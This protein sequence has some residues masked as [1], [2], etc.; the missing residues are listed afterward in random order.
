MIS[1]P[2]GL[3]L[4]VPFCDGK[5]FYCDFY[6]LRAEEER[7][8]AYTDSME[9]ALSAWGAKLGRAA[10]TL[11]FGGGTP[12]L[13]GAERVAALVR[14]AR[15]SFQLENAEITLE[16]NPASDL[17][18]FF[19]A[20]R[21][22]GVNRL[23]I[24][25]QSADEDELRLLGRRHTA[26]QAADAVRAAR[27]AGFDNISLDLMLATPGQTKD[28]LRRSIEF[29]AEAG[30][31]HVSAYLLAVEP[32]TAFAKRRES[33]A[34]PDDGEAGERY[35]FA[36][37]ELERYGFLQYEIS[38][39]A[40][41]GF[42]SR[43]NLKYWRCEEYLGLGPAAHSFLD[44]KRFYYGRSLRDFLQGEEPVPD[45]EGGGFEEYAM[46]ALRLAE[47]LDERRC[48]E[49]FGTGIPPSVWAAERVY[50]RAGLT[51]R[52]AGG[53]R[54]TRR[55]FLVSNTLLAELLASV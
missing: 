47:G 18:G 20:I 48:R 25:L 40:R 3:Y 15:D 34:L 50:E 45:G 46:L 7:M 33:L 37:E 52:T 41:P 10:D 16:A 30:A 1:S 17:G 9:G 51:E 22:A 54:L 8:E 43:H 6:S 39:F 13:L 12:N 42:E 55:G 2:I 38:N 4:H 28:S 14:A 26:K 53:F 19:E 31:R 23:S 21:R 24:G 5:C 49:R 27:E 32:G 36:C 44:G 29:C 11:Y 35:R